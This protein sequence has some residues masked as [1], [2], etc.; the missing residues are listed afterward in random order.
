MRPPHAVI[1]AFAMLAGLNLVASGTDR[2]GLEWTTKPLLMPLLGAYVW[3]TARERG[4]RPDRLVL[5]AL[6][7]SAGGDI[8]LLSSGTRWFIIG[9][10]LFLTAQICYIAAFAGGGATRALRRPPLVA[11]PVGYAVLTVAALA[12]MWPGLVDAGLALPIAGYA[13]ALS[14]MATTAAAHGWR[15][16]LGGG[17]FLVSDLMIAMRV[18]EVAELPGPPIWVMATYVAG[19][20]LIA[21]GWAAR[22]VD[23]P[24]TPTDASAAPAAPGPRGP[25]HCADSG[26]TSRTPG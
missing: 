7:L 22:V 15:V 2:T 25:D 10:A 19:Q 18:A 23:G 21:T 14:T 13:L 11:V 17:L 24:L 1:L 5:A 20:A 12:W 16:G 9:M 8:A 26:R 6:A 3:L 4:T